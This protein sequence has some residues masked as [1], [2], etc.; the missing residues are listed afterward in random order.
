VIIDGL[1]TW[2]R[3]IQRRPV[4]IGVNLLAPLTA[5]Q[6]RA[7]EAGAER[8]GRFLGRPVELAWRKRNPSHPLRE[9]SSRAATVVTSLPGGRTMIAGRMTT[10]CRNALTDHPSQ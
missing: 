8:Y 3:S 2:K 7:L 4:I 6:T 5:V 1:R 9:A 10:T